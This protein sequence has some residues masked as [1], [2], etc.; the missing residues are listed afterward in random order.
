MQSMATQNAHVTHTGATL[1]YSALFTAFRYRGQD[2]DHCSLT[3]VEVSRA[4]GT[5]DPGQLTTR[6]SGLMDHQCR[7]DAVQEI[8]VFGCIE[9][10]VLLVDNQ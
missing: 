5:A 4:D 6:K 9:C 2:T 3:R 1:P 7:K 10:K 8:S